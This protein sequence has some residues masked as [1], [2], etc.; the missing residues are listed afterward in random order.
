MFMYEIPQSLRAFIFAPA[1]M[2]VAVRRVDLHTLK[3]GKV[4][5]T[6]NDAHAYRYN[7]SVSTQL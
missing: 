3:P 4:L 7:E 2:K 6:A 1:C 5:H